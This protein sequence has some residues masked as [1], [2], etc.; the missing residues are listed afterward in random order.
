MPKSTY[1]STS[2]VDLVLRGTV[3]NPPAGIYLALFTVAPTLSTA[4][5]EVTGAGYQRVATTWAA[6]VNGQTS[7]AS[8]LTFPVATAAWGTVVA[9]GLYDASS[10]GHLLYFAPLNASR[11]VQINDQVQYPV[12]Q[13]VVNES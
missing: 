7:N 3:F 2:L 13:L 9:Y 12:G 11:T 4:G 10:G 5:T 1:L 6:T 8:V